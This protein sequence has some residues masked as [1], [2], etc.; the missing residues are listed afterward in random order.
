MSGIYKARRNLCSDGRRTNVHRSSRTRALGDKHCLSATHNIHG[1]AIRN[2]QCAR[3]NTIRRFELAEGKTS[4]TMATDLA[5]RPWKTAGF[6]LIDERENQGA[7]SAARARRRPV[8]AEFGRVAWPSVIRP[9]PE[10]LQQKL[11]S[12]APHS[13]RKIL[14]IIS[15]ANS[16]R[17]TYMTPRPLLL[18]G[19]GGLARDSSPG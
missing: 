5:V 8:D 18:V 1:A 13:G 10:S 3:A 7:R 6:D 19:A 17:G 14:L 12:C 15:Y 16:F 11:L 2:R 9:R 4:L